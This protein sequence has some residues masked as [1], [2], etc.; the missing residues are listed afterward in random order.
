[1]ST[2]VAQWTGREA[3]ALRVAQ[4]VSIRDFASRLGINDSAVSSWERRG[5]E[6]QLRHETQQALDTVLADAPADVQARFALLLSPASAPPQDGTVAAPSATADAAPPGPTTVGTALDKRSAQRTATMLDTIRRSDDHQV[7][8]APFPTVVDAFE[9]FLTSTA[10]VFVLTGRPGSGKTH[11]TYHL[12]ST[13]AENTDF[14]LHSV[15]SWNPHSGD[16]AAEILRYASISAG[17]DPL[18]TLEQTS[19]VLH[20]P[21][22]VVIDGISTHA[23]LDVVGRQLD[24]VL[25][26]VISPHLRFVLVVRTPP[27]ID[28]SGYP[29]VAASLY[30]PSPQPSAASVTVPLWDLPTA[31]DVWN[32]ARGTSQ[33]EF[34]AL[35]SAVRELTRLPLYMQLFRAAGD[36]SAPDRV[37]AFR[38]VDHCVRALLR[39]GGQNVDSALDAL[40]SV[41]Q[42][43]QPHLIPTPLGTPSNTTVLRLDER[44]AEPAPFLPLLLDQTPAG[45]VVFAHDVICEYLL[46]TRIA[47][48]IT[49]LRRSATTVTALNQLA[50]AATTSATARGVFEFVVF[51]LDDRDPDLTAALALA[52]TTAVATTLPMMLTLARAGTRFATGE[53]LRSCAARS[54]TAA[55][56][57]LARSLLAAPSVTDA[58]GDGY[59]SW[60]LDIV[61]RFGA[62]I[63]T[64]VA[65]HLEQALDIRAATRLLAA[66]DLDNAE[67]AI[68][69]ARHIHL[70]ADDE[71]SHPSVVDAL[72]AHRDWRVRAALADCVRSERTIGN[73]LSGR[74]VEQLATDEDYKVRAAT[75]KTLGQTDAST[76][77]DHLLSFL[78][79][80]NWHVR[81]CAL[82]GLLAGAEDSAAV[83][84]LRRY[85]A[86]T[87]TSEPSWHAS[88]R[89]VSKLMHRLLL[90]DGTEHPAGN[91]AARAHALFRLLREHRTG[92]ICLPPKTRSVLAAEGLGSA[93]WLTHREAQAVTNPGQATRIPTHKETYRRHRDRRSIQIALD[94]HDLDHAIV[95]AEAA[96]HAGADFIE[97]GD[98]LIKTIGLAA[99]ETIKRHVPQSTLVAEMMSSD[100]GRDQVELAVEAGADVVLLIG[101][102]SVASVTAAVTAGRRLGAAILL[103]I[104]NTT[105]TATQSWVRDMERA[106]VDGFSVTTNID[107]GVGVHHPLATARTIRAWT[108]LPVAVSG[109]FSTTDYPIIDSNDWDIMIVGRSVSE[110]VQP[111]D[112]ARQIIT[113]IHRHRTRPTP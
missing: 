86:D 18:L 31:R 7:P 55:T 66:A 96:A 20:R 37:N 26:Q 83:T 74:I 17:A 2:V 8:Y 41:A 68:F 38:L 5:A 91:P 69:L 39:M 42:T 102:A 40:A 63:W 30:E 6:A 34:A 80:T 57:D 33:P 90:L 35:P 62:G 50:Q 4:R 87:V 28:L 45:D 113:M 60:L 59:A 43:A 104:P 48:R 72:L 19:L 99:I 106:G 29:I 79:D 93:N 44:R 71:R 108:R 100:W 82:E 22:V 21:C 112:A 111:E 105:A 11:L 95:V 52:P 25:R 61:R 47:A 77:S 101:P 67:E 51:A 75:A 64:D 10:R 94:L 73:G 84:E 27:E 65:D 9:A 3:R 107:L 54:A 12:A 109:G 16:L 53:V 15:S 81:G 58:L 46:A 36:A 32:S 88:P 1:M 98:P 70:F 13:H 56:P 76:T 78:T 92:W 24:T 23:Q 103:D 110:A 97:V 14:Q 49:E 89:H 85:A